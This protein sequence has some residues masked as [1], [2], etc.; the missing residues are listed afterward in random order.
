MAYFPN[1]ASGEILDTQCADCPAFHAEHAC[2]VLAVQM[3]F[4][5]D[6][7]KE[8]NK[9]LREAMTMLVS[10]AGLC[11]VKMAWLDGCNDT[12]KDHDDEIIRLY[13][14]KMRPK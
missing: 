7:Q 13:E 12:D 11:Q 5:Y 3:M 2:P 8:G 10:D 6:Q 4:N 1:G 14:E 9:Q